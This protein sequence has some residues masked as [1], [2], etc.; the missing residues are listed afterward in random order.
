MDTNHVSTKYLDDTMLWG[1]TTCLFDNG[2]ALLV[3]GGYGRNRDSPSTKSPAR[4]NQLFVISTTQHDFLRVNQD[5]L[6]PEAR[7]FSTLHLIKEN[8]ECATFYMFGGRGSPNQVFPQLWQLDL[9]KN[10]KEYA[11]SWT[12]LSTEAP[13]TSTRHQSVY[14]ND[15]LFVFDASN[16]L[17]I[18][19]NGKWS[20]PRICP[21]S[22]L[23]PVIHSQPHCGET[24]FT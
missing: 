22:A 16:P 10:S 9:I 13:F 21:E 11:S 23:P 14:Y 15:K 24:A 18:F 5:S 3:F 17:L 8:E 4:L 7:V 12:L 2:H 19:H 6:Q 1:H 20:K